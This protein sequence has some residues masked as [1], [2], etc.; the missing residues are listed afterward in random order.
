MKYSKQR[1]VILKVVLDRWDHPTS[2]MIYED[3]KKLIP[4]ISLGTV[5]RNLNQ[6]AEN[7]LI[8]KVSVVGQ[9]DRFDKT[10]NN[11]Y[12]GVCNSCGKVLDISMEEAEFIKNHEFSNEKFK[13]NG[14]TVSFT[15]TCDN[16]L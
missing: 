1:E 2:Q 5:Y 7:N 11:H 4:N 3:V 13:V 12:H 16:C 14:H 8:N 15:G 10:L 6:L 9:D